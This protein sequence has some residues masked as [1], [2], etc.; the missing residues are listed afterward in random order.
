AGNVRLPGGQRVL[1]V[2]YEL[3]RLTEGHRTAPLRAWRGQRRENDLVPGQ[4]GVGAQAFRLSGGGKGLAL[5]GAAEHTEHPGEPVAVEY[6]RGHRLLPTRRNGTTAN[7]SAPT[8]AMRSGSNP[9]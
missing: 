1:V 4:T 7:R 3:D 6:G 8:A 2:E 9:A 5:M